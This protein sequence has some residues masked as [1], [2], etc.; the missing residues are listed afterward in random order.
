MKA[1]LASLI[2]LTAA[3]P[4]ARANTIGAADLARAGLVSP[5]IIVQYSSEL[6]LT[7]EQKSRITTLHDEATAAAAPLEATV[8][9]KQAALEAL[10]KDDATTPEAADAALKEL[11]DAE[12]AV[13][14]LQIRTLIALRSELNA[15]QRTE[16]IRL[17]RAE[18]LEKMPLEARVQE[19]ARRLRAAFDEIGI[20]PPAALKEKGAAIEA[21]LTAGDLAAADQALDGLIAETGLLDP[22]PDAPADFAEQ[23]P[24][25]TDLD[26][27]KSRLETVETRA[28][29][30]TRLPILRQLLKA[31]DA[32][33][34]AK[35][36]EDPIQV[37]RILTWAESVLM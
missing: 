26:T 31:K 4:A 3:L 27:L 14:S 30:V 33:E 15:D 29:E 7:E 12:A 16:A 6:G 17:A 22:V 8:K 9:E 2:L 19:K 32:L 24:G 18:S 36:A 25:A 20:E 11:L 28:R 13:K 10:V 35:A 34:A 21:Q 1:I 5:D 37:G 23:D